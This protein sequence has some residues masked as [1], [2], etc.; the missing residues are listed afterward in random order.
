MYVCAHD[1]VVFC[2]VLSPLFHNVVERGSREEIIIKVL[3]VKKKREALRGTF[4]VHHV[5][6]FK[7]CVT[8]ALLPACCRTTGLVYTGALFALRS[9]WRG[10]KSS[11]LFPAKASGHTD[12]RIHAH[13]AHTHTHTHIAQNSVS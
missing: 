2:V 12:A 9:F 7:L 5:I 3:A 1:S 4:E 8:Q 6:L 10:W 13:Y 11:V